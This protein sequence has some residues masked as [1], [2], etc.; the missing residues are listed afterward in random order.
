M[1][2]A[3]PLAPQTLRYAARDLSELQSF[4]T[5]MKDKKVDLI[6]VVIPDPKD[7]YGKY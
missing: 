4:F 3:R 2:I 1:D 7:S 5:S 6:V